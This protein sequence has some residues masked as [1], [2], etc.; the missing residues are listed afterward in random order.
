MV[1]RYRYSVE[2][3][4]CRKADMCFAGRTSDVSL[5][6]MGLAL[7]REVVIALAQGGNLLMP[8]DHF[9]VIFSP[10]V[11]SVDGVIGPTVPARVR[12]VRRLSQHD[13][14]VGVLFEELEEPQQKALEG[15]VTQAASKSA[16]TR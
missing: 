5:S 11:E 16:R 12:H 2:V 1:P 4:I 10:H 15:I 7:T 14:H 13:Y 6:G 8:G 3:T 9:D